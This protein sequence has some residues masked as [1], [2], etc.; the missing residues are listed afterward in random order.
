MNNQSLAREGVWKEG[1]QMALLATVGQVAWCD[2]QRMQASLKLPGPREDSV[3][4]GY[5]SHGCQ[6]TLGLSFASLRAAQWGFSLLPLCGGP[7]ISDQS[8]SEGPKWKC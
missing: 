3:V 8:A 7:V 6:E 5:S 4:P 1:R 2:P